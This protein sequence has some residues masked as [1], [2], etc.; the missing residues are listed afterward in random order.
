MDY[1]NGNPKCLPVNSDGYKIKMPVF[2]IV[3][4]CVMI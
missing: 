4:L 3:L 2:S 1:A